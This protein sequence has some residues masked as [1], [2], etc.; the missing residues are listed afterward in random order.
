MKSSEY[1]YLLA[2]SFHLPAGILSTLFPGPRYAY[3]DLVSQGSFHPKV[4]P[5]SR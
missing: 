5:T 3:R 1:A 4:I 2:R